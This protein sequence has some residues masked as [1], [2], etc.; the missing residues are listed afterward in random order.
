M[1]T[2]LALLHGVPDVELSGPGGVAVR[3]IAADSRAVEPQF[4]FAALPGAKADGRAFIDAA[5]AAGASAVLGPAPRPAALP[6]TLPYVAAGAPRRALSLV[7]RRFHGGPDEALALVGVT[8]TNGKTTT[9]ELIAAAL[10]AAGRDTATG[11]TL[12]QRAGAFRAPGT[13]T[14]PESPALWSFLAHA[15]DAGCAAAA[16]EVSSAALVADRAY[17]MKF[18]AAVLTGMGHDHLDLHVTFENYLAAKRILFEMLA[19]GTVAV[20]PADDPHA[21]SFRAVTRATVVTFGESDGA[22]WRIADHV[23]DAAGATFRLAGPGFDDTVRTLRPGPWDARNLAAAVAV[24]VALGVDAKTAVRG[25]A[26]V[27]HVDGR[28][29]SVPTGRSFTALVDYAHTPEALERTLALLRRVTRGRVI[30]VFG[31]GGER[32]RAKRPAM[33]RIAGTYADVAIVT[34]DNPRGEDPEAIAREIMGGLAGTP[35]AAHRIAGRAQAIRRAVALAG[36]D[37]AVLVTGKGHETYQEIRGVR[38]HFDDREELAA[39]LA[40]LGRAS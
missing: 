12:G 28:W 26:A 6:A 20:L 37:D 5:L 7:A 2:L 4:L 10:G 25:A 24:A 17:G 3:G 23:P 29:Q 35:A 38:A 16:I 14:T 11:G 18:A 36:P 13:L 15:R 40:A 1:T 31:C 33:G 22:T 9:T 30:V 19:P 27:P 39:A 32:D 21:A 34:E 8:G